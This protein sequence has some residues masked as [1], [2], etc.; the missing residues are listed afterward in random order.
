MEPENP[1]AEAGSS[2]LSHMPL[3]SMPGPDVAAP[4][5]SRAQESPESDIPLA[6]Q[7]TISKGAPSTP[8][9][10]ATPVAEP[11]V[12]NSPPQPSLEERLADVPHMPMYDA[13]R[14]IVMVR[15]EQETQTREER[16]NPVLMDNLSKVESVVPS[17]ATSADL[18]REVNS[19][20]RA[21][22]RAEEFESTKSSLEIR[23][24][25]RQLDLNKKVE[26][27]RTEYLA[28]H[29]QWAAHCSKLDEVAKNLALQEAAAT[30]GRTTRRSAASMGDA[31]R[32]DL[33]ME[34][35]IAS[36]GNEELTDATHLGARNAAVIPDMISVTV[37][38]VEY[39]FDD[40]NKEVENPAEYYAPRTGT[41]DWTEE[42]VAIF[43]E[44][45]AQFPKQFGI[46][47]DF[48]PH[49]TPSQCVTFYYLHKT[50]H[51]DFRQ[52]VASRVVKRKRGGRKQKSNALLTDI[53]QKDAEAAPTRR[54]RTAALLPVSEP[55]K[56][57]TRRAALQSENTPT[58]TPTP[59]P[60]AEPRK[61][62]A[63]NTAK[64]AVAEEDEAN[65]DEEVWVSFIFSSEPT[66]T[67]SLG[68]YAQTHE[69]R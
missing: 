13:L 18:I 32:S 59:E 47:A 7:S 1:T 24:A 43:V 37:G 45:F 48:L 50:K 54:R 31:V 67:L 21:S 19:G 49:K 60:E 44:K 11:A 25:K 55:R 6:L 39:A 61:R 22:A 64:V 58:A 3:N 63:R 10:P 62:R 52:V 41:Y 2:S 23:F 26:R 57:S 53:R 33:E 29:D 34:Q 9:V 51:I 56:P 65:N 12:E 35:I 15:L 38:E 66:L 68:C 27:L 28:L 40:T 69:A 16:V 42:E 46:I 17:V 36:L 5:S 30:A 14:V 8:S 20:G 4:L